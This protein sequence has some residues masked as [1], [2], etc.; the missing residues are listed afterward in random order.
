MT[1]TKFNLIIVLI[2]YLIV[3]TNQINGQRN[4]FV[5]HP[6][7]TPK[8]NQKND[9]FFSIGGMKNNSA[10]TKSLQ[11]QLGYSPL[12]HFGI[13]IF[14]S[15]F[16]QLNNISNEINQSQSIYGMNIGYYLKTKRYANEKIRY[17]LFNLSA[18]STIG[19][20]DNYFRPNL[21][22]VASKSV[23]LSLQKYYLQGELHYSFM[24]YLWIGSIF[25]VGK[26]NFYEG[27][28]DGTNFGASKSRVFYIL[29]NP[30]NTFSEISFKI[31]MKHKGLGLYLQTTSGVAKNL[32]EKVRIADIGLTINMNEIHSFLKTKKNNK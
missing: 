22:T 29:T 7:A 14:H 25:R 10:L 3:G 15:R 17:W 2:I 8:F 26:I 24:N 18:G 12:E 6:G 31:E 27:L 9:L 30:K 11:A 20:L 5:P 16:T 19:Q 28:L 1:K 21:I 4:F 13:S 23:R 32:S